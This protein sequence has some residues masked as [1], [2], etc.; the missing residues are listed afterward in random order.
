MSKVTTFAAALG[1]AAVCIAILAA[2]GAFASAD[3]GTQTLK[4]L[5]VAQ[6]FTTVPHMGPSTPPA[7]GGRL[8]FE[9][10]LYNRVPQ[11]GKPAGARIGRAEVVCTIVTLG[12][13][14][15]TITAHVPDG[16]LAAMG[17]MIMRKGPATVHYGVVG[18]T[19]PYSNAHGTTTGRDV[20]DTKSFVDIQLG[21]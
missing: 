15:C 8:I 14:Q 19:G 7:I 6:H 1:S 20:S 21:S 18:G 13:A 17:G 16:Q 4:F 12:H 5:S 11:F 3:A 10:V 9:D 2:G